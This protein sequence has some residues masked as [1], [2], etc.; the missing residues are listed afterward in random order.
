MTLPVDCDHNELF[1]GAVVDCIAE[2]GFP[3]RGVIKAILSDA[4]IRVAIL[5]DC[6]R[7]GTKYGYN[8][9]L[10]GDGLYDEGL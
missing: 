4:L 3:N 10:L 1:E 6:R 7:A 9:R 5:P 2:W 8:V